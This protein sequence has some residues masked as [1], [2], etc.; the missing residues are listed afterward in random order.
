VRENRAND[1]GLNNTLQLAVVGVH[2]RI[3][4]SVMDSLGRM[5]PARA[6]RGMQPRLGVEWIFETQTCLPLPAIAPLASIYF[7]EETGTIG[8][9]TKVKQT[10]CQIDSKIYCFLVS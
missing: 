6:T 2:G 1:C 7:A 3:T 10:L 5:L 8:R 9:V 4:G